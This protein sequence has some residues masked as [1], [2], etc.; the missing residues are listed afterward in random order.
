[1]EVTYTLL[2][3]GSSDRALLPFLT[4]LLEHHAPGTAVQSQWA[5]FRHLKS[6]PTGVKD[7]I[8]TAVD[9]YP[10]DLLFVHRDAESF[11]LEQRRAELHVILTELQTEGFALPIVCVVPV[12]MQEAWLVIDESAIRKASGNP[13][14]RVQLALPRPAQVEAI[15]DPKE[16]LFSLLRTASGHRGRRLSKLPVRALRYR[17][18]ELMDDVGMLRVLPAF[19]AL[20][21]ELHAVIRETGWN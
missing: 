7:R 5:D 3:D 19:C 14:G 20:E 16:L 12:R 13:E 9:L 17:V 8:K 21:S 6:P 18:A 4:W 10:C 2:S 15:A 1:M 11:S